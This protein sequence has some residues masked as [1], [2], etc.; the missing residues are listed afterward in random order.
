MELQISA[1]LFFLSISKQGFHISTIISLVFLIER[2][3]GV[4]KRGAEQFKS[5]Y[6]VHIPLLPIDEEW[7]SW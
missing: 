5:N 7:K 4:K 3:L 6:V 2:I 1:G